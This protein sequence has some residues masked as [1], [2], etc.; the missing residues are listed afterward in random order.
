MHIGQKFNIGLK[1]RLADTDLSYL[2]SARW[3]V[4]GGCRMCCAG[5]MSNS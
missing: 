3:M 1:F 4:D 2:L 5:H